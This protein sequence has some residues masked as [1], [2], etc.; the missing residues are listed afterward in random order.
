M[1][2][3]GAHPRPASRLVR[4]VHHRHARAVPSTAQPNTLTAVAASTAITA[5]YAA[6]CNGTDDQE[7]VYAQ[8]GPPSYYLVSTASYLTSSIPRSTPSPTSSPQCSKGPEARSPS[9]A[10]PTPGR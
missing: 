8:S 6:L 4:R 9:T 10:P 7:G 2:A 3:R 1:T 5:S